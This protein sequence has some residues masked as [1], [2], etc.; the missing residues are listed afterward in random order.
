MIQAPA[1]M[2][3]AVGMYL[4]L[5]TTGAIFLGGVFKWLADR[6]AARRKLDTAGLEAVEQRGTMLASG[7]IAGEAIVA[8]LLSMASIAASEIYH[9]KETTKLD[10]TFTAWWSGQANLTLYQNYG[11]WLSLLVFAVV[12]FCLVHVPLAGKRQ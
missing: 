1:P 5:E 8:I 10:F 4:P 7:F 3:I 6:A 12:G 2:L 11:G 9:F